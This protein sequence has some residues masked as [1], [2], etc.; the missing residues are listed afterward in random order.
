MKKHL[1]SVAAGLAGGLVGTLFVRELTKLGPKL[2]RSFQPKFHGD[3]TE[4]VWDKTEELIGRPIPAET[5]HRWAPALAYLYGV[6]GP[7]VLGAAAHKLGRGSLGRTLAA[8]AV[9]GGIVWAVGSLGWLPRAGVA[10][11]IQRQPPLA[12]ANQLVGHTAYGVLSAL[13]VALVERFV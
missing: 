6:T 7:L 3:P 4:V 5:R 10:E 11:P 12:T 2:P 1:L 9:M 13:P 8:G